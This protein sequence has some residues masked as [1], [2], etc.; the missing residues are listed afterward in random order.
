[1]LIIAN[2]HDFLTQSGLSSIDQV[3]AFKGECLKRHRHGRRDVLRIPFP[4]ENGYPTALFL[5][6]N[7]RPYTK[8]GLMSLLRRGSVW[9]ASRQEWANSR[10]L[11]SAGVRVAGPVAY[12]EQCS[13][14]REEFSFLITEAAPGQSVDQFLRDT[15]DRTARRLVL[16][17]LARFIRRFH[18][19]GF[20]TPDLF[21]RHV[22]VDAHATEPSFCLIDVARLDATKKLSPRKRARDLAALNVTAPLRLLSARERLRFLKIYAGQRDKSLARLIARRVSR[23]LTRRKYRHFAT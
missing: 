7:W 5:K 12:G 22:F 19:A 14:F 6:R 16:D 13:L 15:A 23:L 21:T 20:A 17:A 2:H 11:E 3:K 18:S 8:D 10:A 9:S 1:L 4:S